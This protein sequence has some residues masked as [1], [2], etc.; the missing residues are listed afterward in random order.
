MSTALGEAQR[1]NHLV[2]NL[3]DMS[4]VEAEALHLTRDL[5]EV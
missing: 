5:N 2:R 1:L 3:L 4:R